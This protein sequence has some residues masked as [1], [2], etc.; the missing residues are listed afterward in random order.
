MGEARVQLQLGKHKA[1]GVWPADPQKM[2]PGGVQNRLTKT[3]LPSD[4]CRD[5]NRC[6]AALRPHRTD[7]TGHGRGGSSYY[8]EIGVPGKSSGRS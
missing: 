7:D 3:I 4:A 6:L 2:G 5:D 8:G 1:E